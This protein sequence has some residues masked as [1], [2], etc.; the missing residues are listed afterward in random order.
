MALVVFIPLPKKIPGK[1]FSFL[2][3]VHTGYESHPV[4][5]LMS[6][7]STFPRAKR[8]DMKLIMHLL[9]LPRSRIP[10]Y[11]HLLSRLQGTVLN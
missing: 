8:P 10:T 6:N 3:V 11:I 2:H 4:S 1:V 5:Y 9:L 7:G